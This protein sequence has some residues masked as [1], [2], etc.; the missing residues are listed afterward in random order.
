MTQKEILDYFNPKIKFKRLK[1]KHDNLK[2]KLNK[3][4]NGE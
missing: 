4:K 1:Y 3:F 2:L